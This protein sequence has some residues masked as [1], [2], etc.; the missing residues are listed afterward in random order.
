MIRVVES[1]ANELRLAEARAFVRSELR[2]R[3]SSA[4]R[5]VARRG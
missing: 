2:T 5:R 4:C 1:A 3:Q